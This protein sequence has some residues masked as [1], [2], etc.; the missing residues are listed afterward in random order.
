[1]ELNTRSAHLNKMG[2]N[3]ERLSR[4][5]LIGA[6]IGLAG[7]ATRLPTFA[8]VHVGH[9]LSAWTNTPQKKGLFILA[10]DF[11]EDMARLSVELDTQAKKGRFDTINPLASR[12]LDLTGSRDDSIAEPED[13]RFLS[14]FKGA[15]DHLDYSK[16]SG[17]A[18]ENM[19]VGFA[20]ML[21]KTEEIFIRSE[22][23][24]A[25]AEEA[26]LVDQ[27]NIVEIA[28][29]LRKLTVLNFEGSDSEYG[30][31]QF[32]DDLFEVL[33]RED[34]PYI[35]P[36]KKYLFGVIRLPD[37]TWFWKFKS[38]AT[39]GGSYGQFD[40]DTGGGY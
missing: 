29:E 4:I 19:R 20:S 23:I 31:R 11:A 2:K 32:R 12:L 30:L 14:A 35:A 24:V 7:C 3:F 9:S 17:D 25:L 10:E 5:A 38:S 40:A 37:G 18:T 1:M 22:V 28:A 21:P 27:E 8:H 39:G 26:L 34:P 15:V 16:E 13:Y 6:V 33:S 36:E